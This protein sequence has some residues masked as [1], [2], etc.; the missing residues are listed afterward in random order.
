MS[1]SMFDNL[2]KM[3]EILAYIFIPIV[4]S[5][6]KFMVPSSS[7]TES[8][9]GIMKFYV[10]VAPTNDDSSRAACESA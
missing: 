7:V 10:E 6:P 2:T 4:T 1:K 8:I 3:K 9:R 5:F